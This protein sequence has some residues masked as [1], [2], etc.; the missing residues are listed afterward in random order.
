M[1]R[2]ARSTAM[3]YRLLPAAA[4]AALLTACAAGG[5]QHALPAAVRARAVQPSGAIAAPPGWT[6]TATRGASVVHGA[7]AGPLAPSTPLTV[8]LGLSLRNTDQLRASIAARQRITPAQFA[9]QFGPLPNDVQAVVAYLREQGFHNVAAQGQLVSADGTA[10][11]AAKAFATTLESFRLG[12]ASLYAN[13]TPAFV[14]ASLHGAVSAVLG[15]NNAAKMSVRMR[16]QVACFAGTSLPAGQCAPLFAA[17]DVQAFYDAGSTAD[18]TQTSV[19]VMAAGDMTQVVADLQYAESKQGLPQVPLTLVTVGAASSDRSNS[20]EWDLDTQASTGM[21]QNVG[22]LFLY[23]TTSLSDADISNLYNAWLSNGGA[24]ASSSFGECESQASLDGSM[25]VDD[26]LL[27]TAASYGRTMF[28]SSGDSGSACTLSANGQPGPPEVEYPASSPYVVA[29]GGTTV[30]ANAADGSYVGESAWVDGGGG[31]SAL[32]TAASWQQGVPPAGTGG[33]VNPRAVPDIAM[34]GDPNAGSYRVYGTNIPGTGDCSGGCAV[35]GTSEA[36]PL[37]MGAYAR[38][39]SAHVNEIGYAAP[40]LYRDFQQQQNGA[41][42]VAG[43]PPTRRL[44]GFHDI[45]TG[46]NGAY[47]AAPGYDYTTGL[48]TLDVN[49]MNIQIAN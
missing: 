1:K 12:G 34:A 7:D 11:Q 5:A 9:A 3:T 44:G 26:N 10:A 35:G 21:A 32:E 38:I 20:I 39:L 30:V 37:A 2:N 46:S 45:L 19:A 15:L 40:L 28:V 13:T 6:A 14:P 41:T 27:M 43:P 29:V 17:Q 48:G 22:M 24:V 49:L 16:A 36:A 4:L 31:T 23:A 8:R 33:L 47:A 18:G 25:A 42:A